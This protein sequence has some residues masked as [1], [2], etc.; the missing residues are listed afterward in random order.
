M[1]ELIPSL[2]YVF[3]RAILSGLNLKLL[4]I[5][6]LYIEMLEQRGYIVRMRILKHESH[7]L[8]IL[9]DDQ[10]YSDKT[11]KVAKSMKGRIR[12]VVDE[13]S[14]HVGSRSKD[15]FMMLKEYLME[16]AVEIVYDTL[17]ENRNI[18]L[19]SLYE[20]TYY[21]LVPFV[22]EEYRKEVV[23]EIEDVDDALRVVEYLDGILNYFWYELRFDGKKAILR[24]KPSFFSIIDEA[25]TKVKKMLDVLS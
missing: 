18:N 7:I 11:V 24:V 25:V 16:K 12:R 2:V 9:K 10:I 6:Y 3:R 20:M 13:L 21:R 23:F 19:F 4:P 22:P 5:L 14:R 15:D 8:E 17:I 1:D